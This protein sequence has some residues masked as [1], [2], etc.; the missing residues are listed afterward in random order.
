MT[1]PAKTAYSYAFN[2]A[3]AFSLVVLAFNLGNYLQ[4]SFPVEGHSMLPAIRQ[5]DLAIVQPVDISTMRVGDMLVYRDGDIYVI[6]RVVRVQTVGG[7]T[8]LTVKGDNNGYPDPV[9]VTRA[10]FVGKVVAVI[11]YFGNFVQPPF[12]Y[13]LAAILVTLLAVDFLQSPGRKQQG[14]PVSSSAH[15]SSYH[16]S[17]SG[18][19]KAFGSIG[20][21]AI[22]KL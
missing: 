15:F 21:E 7:D 17:V 8:V 16:T 18:T 3:V 22:A 13:I 2:V 20:S 5:G 4:V 19:S 9:P 6:H 11:V 14:D 12:N 10:L 1:S